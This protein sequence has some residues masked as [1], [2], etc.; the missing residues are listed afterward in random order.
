MKTPVFRFSIEGTLALFATALIACGAP[1]TKQ[2]AAGD[3]T[4]GVTAESKR[5]KKPTSQTFAAL[6]NDQRLDVLHAFQARNGAYWNV[7]EEGGGPNVWENIDA[8]RPFLRLNWRSDSVG[9]KTTMAQ[10]DALALTDDFVLRNL[11]LLGLTED[12]FWALSW[13]FEPTMEGNPYY[14]DY[15][16]F[17][18]YQGSFSQ[19]GYEGF[20]SVA[21]K[22]DLQIGIHRDGVIRAVL[23]AD[24]VHHP[25]LDISTT[26]KFGPN[27]RRVTAN[28]LGTELI[29]YELIGQDGYRP[30]YRRTDLGALE[31]ADIAARDLTIFRAPAD[32]GSAETFSLAY[33]LTVQ[34]KGE[35][36]TFVVDASTGNVLAS[37]EAPPEWAI[38]VD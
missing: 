18:Q 12:Q 30:V 33:Q 16:Y 17:V 26:P 1:S 8:F 24:T 29:K 19:P 27:D 2:G 3:Q 35:T 32:D 11:D 28:V 10:S 34:K 37:P 9:A 13:Q 23:Q 20:D 14:E 25:D 4:S 21:S 31:K 22:I 36:F 6:T 7:N 15:L 5:H 38:I